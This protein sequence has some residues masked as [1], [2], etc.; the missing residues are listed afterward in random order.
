MSVKSPLAKVNVVVPVL[1]VAINCAFVMLWLMYK[2]VAAVGGARNIC[3]TRLAA[4]I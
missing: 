3:C 2:F 4:P 1:R